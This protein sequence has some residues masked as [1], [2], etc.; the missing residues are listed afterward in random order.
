MS[1]SDFILIHTDVSYNP[2]YQQLHLAT[3]EEPLEE[4]ESRIEDRNLLL[5]MKGSFQEDENILDFRPGSID[6]ARQSFDG[7]IDDY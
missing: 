7:N 5:N 6:A 4:D 2:I 3:Q 1:N